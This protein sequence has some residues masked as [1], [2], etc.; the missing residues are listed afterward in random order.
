MR[1]TLQN[2]GVSYFSYKEYRTDHYDCDGISRICRISSFA[3]FSEDFGITEK[4]ALQIFACF[5]GGMCKGEVCGACTGA[6]IGKTPNGEIDF[7]AERRNDKL[8]V[9]VTQEISS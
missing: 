5:G 3:A 9:Q 7:I 6:L 8:Y 2:A 1:I 4:Q